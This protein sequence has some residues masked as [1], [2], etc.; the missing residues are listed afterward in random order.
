MFLLI[1][2]FLIFILHYLINL[3]IILYCRHS[4]LI[5]NQIKDERKGFDFAVKI[6]YHSYQYLIIL[7][8]YPHYRQIRS[9][10]KQFKYR[11]ISD[12][13]REQFSYPNLHTWNPFS[14]TSWALITCERPFLSKKFIKASQLKN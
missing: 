6:C 9:C 11:Y 5:F 2:W 12:K 4:F 10:T 14:C 7:L 13:A 1:G 8:G 3:Q